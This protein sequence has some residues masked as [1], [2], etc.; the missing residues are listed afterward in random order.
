M[1]VGNAPLQDDMPILKYA[2]DN[3]I[4]LLSTNFIEYYL[5]NPKVIQQKTDIHTKK[6]R[7]NTFV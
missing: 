5:G 1:P 7:T 4:C 3:R 2:C 6:K